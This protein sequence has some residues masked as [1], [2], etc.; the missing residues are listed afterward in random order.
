MYCTFGVKFFF[1]VSDLTCGLQA[2]SNHLHPQNS[3]DKTSAELGLWKIQFPELTVL[4]AGQS[5]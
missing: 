2:R 1:S 3:I 4:L 5:E